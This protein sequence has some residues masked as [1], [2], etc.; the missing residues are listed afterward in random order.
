MSINVGDI[1]YFELYNATE[2]SL[3][4]VPSKWGGNFVKIK[5]DEPFPYVGRDNPRR[6]IWI[7]ESWLIKLGG[8]VDLISIEP[9]FRIKY[10][11]D[12]ILERY[13]TKLQELLR[14]FEQSAAGRGLRLSMPLCSIKEKK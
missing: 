1:V 13:V 10:K 8:D 14:N 5:I 7:H 4:V 3:A 11:D 12:E 6:V 9:E 2:K